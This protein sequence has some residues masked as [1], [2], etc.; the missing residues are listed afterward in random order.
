MRLRDGTG[1][2]AL[3][4]VHTVVGCA[5]WIG[6]SLFVT[7]CSGA[8]GAFVDASSGEAAADGR[9]G[10]GS[11]TGGTAGGS[12]MG[13][14]AGSAGIGGS[15]GGAGTGGIPGGGGGPGAGGSAGVGLGGAS[16][17]GGVGGAA[18]AGGGAGGSGVGAASGAPGTGV[19]IDFSH[20]DTAQRRFRNLRL[21]GTGF[22]EAEGQAVRVVVTTREPSYGLAATTIRSGGF[23]IDLPDAVG[24]YWGIGVYV[25]KARDDA[26]TLGDDPLWQTTTGAT[27]DDVTWEITPRLTPDVNDPPCNINGVFDLTKPLPCPG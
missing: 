26:C 19:C 14:S 8:H 13:G 23:E 10:D 9:L 6:L 4:R 21:I 12:G 7:S 24:I 22:D 11:G 25:D 3:N 20:L 27:S 2:C 5:V 15:A 1:T 18:A 17:R 16:G